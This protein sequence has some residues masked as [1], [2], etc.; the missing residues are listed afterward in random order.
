LIIP[1]LIRAC[2]LEWSLL[3]CTDGVSFKS[4]SLKLPLEPFDVKRSVQTE[5][6]SAFAAC[7]ANLASTGNN[8]CANATA[9]CKETVW[10][11][12]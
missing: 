7:I 3:V 11:L 1:V 12:F 5:V 2:S 10:N 6:E 4:T 9:K 8:I